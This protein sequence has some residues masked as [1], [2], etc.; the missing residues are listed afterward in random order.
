MDPKAKSQFLKK[1]AINGFS[2]EERDDMLILRPRGMEVEAM[3][4]IKEVGPNAWSVVNAAGRYAGFNY[5]KK[6][7][8]FE[9]YINRWAAEAVLETAE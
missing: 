3:V 2:I 4:I 8:Y 6:R 9:T 7:L 5:G 1:L